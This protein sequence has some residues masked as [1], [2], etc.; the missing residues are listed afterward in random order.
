MRWLTLVLLLGGCAS[1]STPPSPQAACE[2]EAQ[3]DPVAR[4]MRMKAAGSPSYLAEEQ[5]RL[6]IV[7]QE[8]TLRCLRARG[9]IRPGG[10]ERQKPL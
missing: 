8:A 9:I 5:E 4:D 3:D 1:M 10:V 6:R 7:I 2:N